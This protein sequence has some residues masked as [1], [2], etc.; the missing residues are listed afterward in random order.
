MKDT[1]SNCEGAGA[2]QAKG[3]ENRKAL[4]RPAGYD[5]TM[6]AMSSKTR[7]GHPATRVNNDYQEPMLGIGEDN[8][9]GYGG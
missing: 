4:S 3:G 6:K 9:K 7:S 1:C 5:A 8:V 2:A